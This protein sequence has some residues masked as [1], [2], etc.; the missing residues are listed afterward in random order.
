[1]A[2]ARLLFYG[3]RLAQA[4]A[5]WVMAWTRKEVGIVFGLSLT[6]LL[7]VCLVAEV[8]L[9]LL[10]PAPVQR[11]A[12]LGWKLKANYQREFAQQSLGGATYPVSFATNDQGL[13][14]F[15]S[16]AAPVKI[17][18]LGDSFTAD[19]FASNDRMWYAA[20]A[21]RLAARLNRPER[22]FYVMGGGGG[23][24]GTYQNLLLSQELA[25]RLKP[26]LFVL[27]F[28][29][30]DFQNNSYDWESKSVARG[31]FMRRPFFI[32]GAGHPQ[33][34]QGLLASIYR[35][36]LGESRLLNRVDGL[37]GSMQVRRYGGYTQPLSP[38]LVAGYESDSVALTQTLL[39]RLRRAYRAPAV[40]VNCD[41]RKVGPNRYWQ[42]IARKAGF[43]PLGAPS[44]FLRS[45]KPRARND[46]FNADGAHLS[47][48]GNA[49]YGAIVGDAIASLRLLPSR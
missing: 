10:R 21:K 37:I 20:M 18:V 14:V 17:L 23:G 34:A 13:R 42:E 40:M 27:Q 30:N 26:D 16:A 41:S 22:D 43:I 24:W 47:E 38:Q 31:Q 2:V 29:S 12:L 49:L 32:A 11:D 4:R 3:Y 15:G 48:E 6:L 39:T 19:P 8:G 45:L 5:W 25:P 44:D 1:M 7:L 46:V 33:Y 35:S 9:A 28:C 36:I